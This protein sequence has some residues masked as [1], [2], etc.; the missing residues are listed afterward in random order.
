[1]HNICTI[2]YLLEKVCTNRIFHEWKKMSNE[3]SI[4]TLLSN[5]QLNEWNIHK[6]VNGEKIK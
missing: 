2:Q 5:K 1:M 4:K 6:I 3:I